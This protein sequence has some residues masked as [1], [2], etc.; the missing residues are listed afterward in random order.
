[1]SSFLPG[2]SGNSP[3]RALRER[4]RQNLTGDTNFIKKSLFFFE[5]K[6]S[7]KI[8]GPSASQFIFPLI[9]AP[10]AYTMSEP[11]TVEATPTQGGG[12]YVEENGIV[13]RMIR[14][15]GTTGW[16]PRPFPRSATGSH[17]LTLPVEK[18]SYSRQL[19]PFIL[20]SISG[21]K[22]FQYL[23]D[24]VFRMYGDLKRDPET[25]EE[26]Q[27]FFHN[28]HD[29]EV[30]LVV[31][32][33]FELERTAEKRVLYQYNI[34][35]LVVDSG[36]AVDFSISEDKS[37]LDK[38]KDSLRMANSYIEM[39]NGFANDVTA[40]LAEVEGLIKDVGTIVNNIGNLATATSALVQGV[41][42]VIEA[43]ASIILAISN[44]IDR[45][46][47][48]LV[49]SIGAVKGI[50][51]TYTNAWRRVQEGLNRLGA[52]KELFETDAQRTLRKIRERQQADRAA[53]RV[54]DEGITAP[55]TLA[56]FDDRGTTPL[57][58]AVNRNQADLGIGQSINRYSAAKV[59][60]VSQGDTLV[61]LAAQYLGDARLWQDIALFN[62]M[63]PPFIDAQGGAELGSPANPI[64]G[65]LGIGSDILI[66]TFG[67]PPEQLPLL[68]VLGASREEPFAT[69]LLG[70][71]FEL[72]PTNARKDQFDWVID[73][74]HGSQDF[75]T[76]SGIPNLSQA[77]TTRTTTQRGFNPL[78]R[79]L[80]LQRIVGFNQI[81]IDIETSRFRL[82]DA[83]TA[84][85]RIGSVRRL[86]FESDEDSPDALIID[87]DLEVRG[88]SQGVKVQAIGV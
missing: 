85:P 14:L 54:E 25:S 24:A 55:L 56:G 5:L 22:H 35:L 15:R 66:P 83:I 79:R 69:Q 31:P 28:P 29:E 17:A 60:T 68:P 76:V 12:L 9:I 43:P 73:V 80:G 10:Q 38:I 18:R 46:T 44:S 30:W 37:L 58:G 26:T 71:D 57:P 32:Q 48:A 70:T 82:L 52:H 6:V 64:P 86:L 78:Y 87:A 7:P 34:E 2:T 51:S 40:T 27:L 75:K 74:E 1:M 33:K 39:A 8:L 41:V 61:N 47:N 21:A 36:Q 88:F 3:I 20:D 77:V 49:T 42:D 67:R 23:Q 4:T 59:V 16:K 13:Q 81:D 50:S 11:F 65:V 72:Q 53:R 63:K 45:T 84:D 62:G 19:S